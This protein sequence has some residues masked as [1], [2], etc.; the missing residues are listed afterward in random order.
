M[1]EDLKGASILKGARG[2]KPAD[3]KALTD[4]IVGVS[5]LLAGNPDIVNLDI[6]PVIVYD[7]GEGCVIIDAKIEMLDR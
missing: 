3:I 6:N 2:G 7:E 5:N 4:V 1:I